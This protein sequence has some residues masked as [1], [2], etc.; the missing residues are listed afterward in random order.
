MIPCGIWEEKN[1]RCRNVPATRCPGKCLLFIGRLIP[2]KGT[3]WFLEHVFVKLHSEDPSLKFIIAG[4]GPEKRRILELRDRLQLQD[5]VSVMGLIDEGE[6]TKLLSNAALFVMPNV[7]TEGDMEGFGIVCIEAS[8]AGTPVL[9]SRMEGITDAVI[10]GKTG[11]FFEPLNA[12]S[13]IQAA[14]TLLGSKPDRDAIRNA[15]IETFGWSKIAAKYCSVFF[16][17]RL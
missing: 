16:P 10:D 15:T 13:C 7:P 2:R 14:R 3:A 1:L 4:E 17:E 12:E 11:R 5:A 9:A 6:K 8:A